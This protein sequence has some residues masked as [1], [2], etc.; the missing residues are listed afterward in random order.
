MPGQYLHEPSGKIL[1]RDAYVHLEG[2]DEAYQAVTDDFEAAALE[3]SVS[4]PVIADGAV[5]VGE[6][7]AYAG[8]WVAWVFFRILSTGQAPH[9]GS[10]LMP[11]EM[12]IQILTLAHPS[13]KPKDDPRSGRGY[14]ERQTTKAY[15]LFEK[16]LWDI[17]KPR[18]QRL[19]VAATSAG[20]FDEFGRAMFEDER[21]RTLWA[22]SADIRV[23]L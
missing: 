2:R 20:S 15:A 17:V 18:C 13:D 6:P 21:Q 12:S 5:Y 23:V 1:G 9:A 8:N 22:H 11:E 7:E 10:K 16:P 19:F 3:I 14:A 4:S